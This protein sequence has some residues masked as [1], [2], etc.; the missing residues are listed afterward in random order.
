MVEKEIRFSD[1][2]RIFCE[3]EEGIMNRFIEYGYSPFEKKQIE[4]NPQLKGLFDKK[5]R[6]CK[7]GKY[8]Y[9][10]VLSG[11]ACKLN[12][13]QRQQLYNELKELHDK[14]GQEYDPS[15]INQVFLHT[16]GKYH[17][18]NEIQC[19][20]CFVTIYLAMLDFEVGKKNYPHSLGKTIVLRSC[21]AVIL[22]NV[23][24]KEAAT[25]FDR[26][27]DTQSYDYDYSEDDS[28]FEKFNGYNGYDDD[29]IDEGFD[30]FPKATWNVE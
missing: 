15:I 9:L 28:R 23:D 17:R 8:F 18:G 24:Y 30:G 1:G 4:K 20:A 2:T 5:V 16:F 6:K 19:A 13:N 11:I 12:D 7:C 14:V 3:E 29:I 27:K 21:E 10:G 22:K 26:K 25:M